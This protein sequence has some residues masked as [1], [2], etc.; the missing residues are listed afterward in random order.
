[1]RSS[2]QEIKLTGNLTATV[3]IEYYKIIYRII[4]AIK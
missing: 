1:M 4:N 2:S 3:V